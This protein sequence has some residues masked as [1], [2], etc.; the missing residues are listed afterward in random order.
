MSTAE[1]SLHSTHRR[2]SSPSF[3]LLFCLATIKPWCSGFLSKSSRIYVR[4]V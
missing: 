4:N 2:R 3:S 1:K